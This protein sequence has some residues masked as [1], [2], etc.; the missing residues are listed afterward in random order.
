MTKPKLLDTFCCAGGCSEGYHRAGFEPYGIDNK[1]QPHYSFP[2]LQMDALEALDRLLRGD[3]LTFSNFDTLSLMDFFA[4]HASPPCQHD[5]VMTKGRWQDRINGHPDL[6]K[7]THDLL[8]VAQIP[9]IIENV[10]GSKDKLINPILLCGTMFG[11]Q[12]KAGSQLRRHRYFEMPWFNAL[13]PPCAHGK[14]SAIGVYGGGQNP[15]RKRT[16]ATI[17]VWGHAG[18][19]S[20]RDGLIQFGTQDRK[21]AMRIDWMTGNELAQAIPPAYTKFIGEYLLK[22]IEGE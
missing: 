19:T 17:G 8:V 21:D 14:S 16:P 12:T 22:A 10:A 2:F 4:I 13:T 1:P 3:C 6:I 7:P 11:L 20:N 9:Y 5:S 18:G 15:D